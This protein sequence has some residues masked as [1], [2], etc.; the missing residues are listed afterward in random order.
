MV[1][2][3]INRRMKHDRC[4]V[5][6]GHVPTSLIDKELLTAKD[7]DRKENGQKI[8]TTHNTI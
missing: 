2:G 6:A 4:R 7:G 8:Q 3:G 1:K 5:P